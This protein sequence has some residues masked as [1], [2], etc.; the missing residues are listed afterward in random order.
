MELEFKLIS[1]RTMVSKAAA[2]SKKK[3]LGRAS[4][5]ISCSETLSRADEIKGAGMRKG[6]KKL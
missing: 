3:I 6:G 5:A 1:A 2:A 4:K